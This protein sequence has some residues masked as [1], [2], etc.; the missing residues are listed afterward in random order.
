MS[1][2]TLSSYCFDYAV[3]TMIQKVDLITSA[4]YFLKNS[5][6]LKKLPVCL[7]LNCCL[8]WQ[9]CICFILSLSLL[10]FSEQ[11]DF[12]QGYILGT[13]LTSTMASQTLTNIPFD[14]KS[15]REFFGFSSSTLSSSTDIAR[16]DDNFL[17]SGSTNIHNPGTTACL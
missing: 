5:Y 7:H 17:V 3:L 13:F 10:N 2:I 15:T 16:F 8:I 11:F 14:I 4:I 9:L 6:I 1:L 12:W